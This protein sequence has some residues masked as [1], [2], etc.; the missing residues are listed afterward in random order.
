VDKS[1]TLPPTRFQKK[2]K[3]VLCYD[4]YIVPAQNNIHSIGAT[5]DRDN[6]AENIREEENRE[7]LNRLQNAVPSMDALSMNIE[8]SRVGIRTSCPGQTPLIG[9]LPDQNGEAIKNIFLSLAYGSRG[10][11]F[12]PLCSE[13]IAAE[14]CGEENPLSERLLWILSALQHQERMKRQ[15]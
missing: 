10:L 7:L 3:T 2:L 13:S 11:I 12:A 1:F 14:I 15:A 6:T 8:S 4:G 5:Y 9:A